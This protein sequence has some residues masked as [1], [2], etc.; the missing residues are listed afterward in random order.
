[1]YEYIRC[2]IGHKHILIPSKEIVR[3]L[4]MLGAIVSISALAVTSFSGCDVIKRGLEEL[5][6]TTSISAI[7]GT[8]ETDRETEETDRETEESKITTQ[9]YEDTEEEVLDTINFIEKIEEEGSYKEDRTKELTDQEYNELLDDLNSV[10]EEKNFSEEANLLILDVFEGLC[11]NYSTW[12]KGYINMPSTKDYITNNLIN[13]VKKISN[14]EFIDKQSSEG[15][16]RI[17]DGEP[18]GFT[19]PNAQGKLDVRIIA[20]KKEDANE[21]D[22]KYDLEI[23]AHEICGHCKHIKMVYGDNSELN[24][25]L[26]EGSATF[27]Q[28]FVNPYSTI[29]SANWVATN[30]DESIIIK[31]SNSSGIGY[32]TY[33][34]AY[35]KLV[36]LLGYDV[37][38]DLE[39]G[40]IKYPNIEKKLLEYYGKE[41][42]KEYAKIMKDWFMEY[43]ENITGDKICKLCLDFED[44]FMKMVGYNIDL[45]EDE[46][47][48]D[49]YKSAF[50][51][52][53]ERNM[54]TAMDNNFKE[55]TSQIFD[56]QYMNK[57]F[58]EK[59]KEINRLNTIGTMYDEEPTI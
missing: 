33:L 34:N 25:M 29:T 16:K 42:G 9:S 15:Q 31:Y 30:N 6:T 58:E 8:E 53:L 52:Y 11:K 49:R 10:L 57:A 50:E 13:S 27:N 43:E 41:N 14:F 23:A 51:Q 22:R 44:S 12:Q 46:Q 40:N 5:E 54:P 28:K 2:E 45:I 20:N 4:K 32:L 17:N 36:F 39:D 24:Q 21:S 3:R 37:I 1:M 59:Q 38:N 56:Y 35:E 19:I 26:V 48:L 47:L 7:Q 55:I 18:L